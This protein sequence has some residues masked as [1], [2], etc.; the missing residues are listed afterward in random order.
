MLPLNPIKN[1]K[2][3]ELL[4]SQEPKLLSER[5]GNSVDLE[6]LKASQ[7]YRSAHD[8]TRAEEIG[9]AA[10]RPKRGLI[11]DAPLGLKF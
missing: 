11:Y 6:K 4:P 3:N 9:T 10:Q 8:E 7:A 1:M 2:F 5:A